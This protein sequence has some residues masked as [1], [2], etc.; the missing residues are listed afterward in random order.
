[1]TQRRALRTFREKHRDLIRGDREPGQEQPGL[2][3]LPRARRPR[4]RR[5]AARIAAVAAVTA[6][7]CLLICQAAGI[8]VLGFFAKWGGRSSGSRAPGRPR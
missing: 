7:S 6:A 4:R 2:K 5:L 3:V 1:M 8:D